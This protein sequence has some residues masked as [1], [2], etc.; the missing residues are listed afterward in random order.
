M[1]YKIFKI[2]YNDGNWHSGD[3]PHF[4]Y[5][6]SD[7]KEVESNSKRYSEFKERQQAFGGD[8]WVHEVS[9]VE[10]PYEWENL[11]DFIVKITAI[12]KEIKQ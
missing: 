6:A 10:F 2:T 4:Y 12:P 9:G 3:L 8:I 1:E 7:E 5:I 11:K